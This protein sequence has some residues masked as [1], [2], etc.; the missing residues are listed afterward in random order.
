MSLLPPIIEG[1]AM[2]GSMDGENKSPS[3]LNTN[4]LNCGTELTDKFCPHCGQKDLPKR[5]SMGE[6]IENFIG[7]FYSF[8]S[9][10]FKTVKYLLFKPGFLPLEYTA[11]RR[12]SYYHPARAYVF[13]S[14]IFFLLF[15]SLPDSNTD[16]EAD[17]I[18]TEQ[19]GKELNKVGL[20]T[21]DRDSSLTKII[22][23]RGDKKD[24]K[25][26]YTIDGEYTTIA[27]YDSIQ[28]TLPET[29]RDG[30]F[31]RK[32]NTRVIE[33]K[34]KYKDKGGDKS[35]EKDFMQTFTDNFS[36]V[37]FYNLPIFALL[38]KLLYMRRDFYYSEHL[39]FSIYYY[40][41]FYLAG[42]VS[43]LVNLIPGLTW[44]SIVIGFWIMVYL[45]LA[46]KRM[47]QQSWR[48]TL[49]KYTIFS[50]LFFVCLMVG[51]AINAVL[52]LMWI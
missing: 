47:Y 4:C 36:K 15:F 52:T 45:L 48:K 6:L 7:S 20:D 27:Q 26:G 38:L 41:F 30:W 14:F 50:I 24:K 35:F 37:L 43:L 33:L 28:N 51:I 32:L 21:L 5:Q 2:E 29:K 1:A 3:P 10:F 44:L 11:G 17:S 42:S 49:L 40:N 31:G 16:E 12:E 25:I 9:K 39:V 23:P 8:E 19:L 46:M 18:Y 22:A 13:I 34:E